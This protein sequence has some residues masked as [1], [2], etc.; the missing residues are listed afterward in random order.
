MRQ[1]WGEGGL[2]WQEEKHPTGPAV[3]LESDT[4]E[5]AHTTGSPA[6]CV[7]VVGVDELPSR[8]ECTS[9]SISSGYK[10]NGN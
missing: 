10:L 9:T 2:A 1:Q 8:T 5:T 3:K 4:P 7:S 6:S